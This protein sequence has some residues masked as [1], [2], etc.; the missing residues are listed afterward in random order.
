MKLL[1][2]QKEH[3]NQ[4]INLPNGFEEEYY[5]PDLD[6]KWLELI[7]SDQEFG[8]W[9]KER[10]HQQIVDFLIEQGGI[11]IKYRD[12]LVAC[13]SIC[14]EARFTPFALLMYVIV[15]QEFRGYGLGKYVTSKAI[16]IARKNGF[17]GVV[18]RT[19]DYRIPA[20]KMYCQF[21]FSYDHAAGLYSKTKWNL[22]KKSLRIN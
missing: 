17:R 11:L 21:G 15:K 12:K 22:L 16:S 10:L 5:S 1:F 8:F 7:N 9:D 3:N 2:T 20:V 19:D 4:S 14:N 6:D 13:A 18:L